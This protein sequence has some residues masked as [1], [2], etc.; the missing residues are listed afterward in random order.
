MEAIIIAVAAIVVN[1]VIQTYVTRA[2]MD[3]K[4][5][6]MIQAIERAQASS[7]RAHERIDGLLQSVHEG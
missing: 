5:E 6:A 4:F 3:A 2:V 1:A 7:D